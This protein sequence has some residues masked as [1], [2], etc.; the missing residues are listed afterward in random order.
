MNHK[1]LGQIGKYGIVGCLNVLVSVA[2]FNLL[3]FLT[4]I[5][6]GWP[7][8]VFFIVSSGVAITHSF[9]WNKFWIFETRGSNTAKKEYTKFFIISVSIALFVT[10]LMH[11]L[12]NVIGAPRGIG[13]KI[14]ANIS[15]VLLIPVSF[16]GNFFSYKFFVFKK[17]E[18]L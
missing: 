18:A 11:I 7:I 16:M 2:L 6:A 10:F 5:A 1:L 15:L 4:G 14:W 9:F 3:M 8:D 13:P 12:V 17:R